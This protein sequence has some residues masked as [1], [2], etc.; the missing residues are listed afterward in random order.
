MKMD[1]FSGKKRN[2]EIL[3]RENFFRTPKLGARSPPLVSML[4]NFAK[5]TFRL[6]LCKL[7]VN[8]GSV[9]QKRADKLCETGALCTT[10]HQ[11]KRKFHCGI[12]KWQ[13]SVLKC[14]GMTNHSILLPS[15]CIFLEFQDRQLQ[16]SPQPR[17]IFNPN[18]VMKDSL[19]AFQLHYLKTFRF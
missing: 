10:S 18:N 17:L 11:W 4:S 15:F 16:F 6:Y 14:S 9:R 12:L 3:V 13:F 5:M 19:C 8:L 7:Y 1:I 2:S